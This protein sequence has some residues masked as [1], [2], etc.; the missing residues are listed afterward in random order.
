MGVATGP[1]G[2]PGLDRVCRALTFKLRV[3]ATSGGPV[4]AMTCRDSVRERLQIHNPT[5]PASSVPSSP[6]L[7]PSCFM[8]QG[9]S[10]LSNARFSRAAVDN[11]AVPAL[12]AHVCGASPAAPAP[13]SSPVIAASH[14]GAPGTL[15]HCSRVQ[16]IHVVAGTVAKYS[17]WQTWAGASLVCM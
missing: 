8:F 5:T 10:S 12:A 16:L 14:H 11:D 17:I 3:Q 6:H 4:A 7:G 2:R 1:W 9:A 13:C 15:E